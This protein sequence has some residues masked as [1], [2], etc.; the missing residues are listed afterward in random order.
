MNNTV[1]RFLVAC[2]LLSIA[3]AGLSAQT[4]EEPEHFS[5][6]YYVL[7]IAPHELGYRVIYMTDRGQ[8]EVTY[9]PMSWFR[10]AAGKA[11]IYYRWED[12]V[13][14]MQVYWL[15]GEFSHVRLVVP[16]TFNHPSWSVVP[17]SVDAESAFDVDTL[18]LHY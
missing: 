8:P 9:L 6:T 3:L 4:A 15:D 2:L 11:S 13:P 10:S 12:S 16:P 17:A 14:Y 18:V 7:R 1:K 5:K